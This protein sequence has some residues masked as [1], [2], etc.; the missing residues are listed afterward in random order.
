MIS[1]C[2][3]AFA[4]FQRRVIHR[5][6]TVRVLSFD[7][8]NLFEYFLSRNS[9]VKVGKSDKKV[10]GEKYK[11]ENIGPWWLHYFDMLCNCS[12]LNQRPPLH[13]CCQ[14]SATLP[15]WPHWAGLQRLESSDCYLLVS[16]T[17][18]TG[19]SVL[20]LVFPIS[21]HH[22]QNLD[23]H[24]SVIGHCEVISWHLVLLPSPYPPLPITFKTN[25]DFTFK[26]NTTSPSKL[27]TTSPST[28]SRGCQGTGD[29]CLGGGEAKRPTRGNLRSLI[30]AG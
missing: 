29:W 17:F 3:I 27:S 8:V 19:A 16:S 23:D 6:A 11:R 1:G 7:Q 4:C 18:F 26:T 22:L 13:T 12:Y 28:P 15:P 30:L 14:A 10:K 21:P 9:L 20:Q 25:Y 2:P 5:R 24:I